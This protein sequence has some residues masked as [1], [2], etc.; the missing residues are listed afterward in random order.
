M[1]VTPVHTRKVHAYDDLYILLQ[2]SL[3]PLKERSILAISSKIISLCEGAVADLSRDKKQLVQE[4]ADAYISS[5][6][7]DISLTKKAG[8]LVPEAGVDVSNAAGYYVLYPRNL[9]SSVN[10]IGEW[11]RAIY[12]LDECGVIITDSHTT[13][14]RRG[15]VGIGLCWYG[16]NACYSYIGKPDCF[17][18]LL[19]VSQ[20][21]L[22]DALSVASV[23][24]M[25]EGDEQTPLAIIEDAPKI[26]FHSRL[27]TQDDL[28]AHTIASSEDLYGPLLHAISWKNPL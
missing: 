28:N 18:R 11:V 5:D 2:E 24:C 22:V 25:G 13:P 3:P 7:Y 23:L 19:Q 9:L 15:V 6:V 16:F 17:G 12:K 8:I 26:S 27:T 1:K 14:M 20:I 4:E 21:N 10:A